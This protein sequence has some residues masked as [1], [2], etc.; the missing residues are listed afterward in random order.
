MENERLYPAFLCNLASRVLWL[1]QKM[2]KGEFDEETKRKLKFMTDPLPFEK[3]LLSGKME[4]VQ[5]AIEG[6]KEYVVE[7]LLPKKYVGPKMR[8]DEMIA[9]LEDDLKLLNK[10][11][12]VLKENN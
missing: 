2:E 9:K 10:L 12:K 7:P 4:Q 11:I 3:E 5:S 6:L 8:L 1:R